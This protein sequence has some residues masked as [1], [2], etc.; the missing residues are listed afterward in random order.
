MKQ[1]KSQQMQLTPAERRWLPWFGGGGKLAMRWS[2]WLNRD[3][4]QVLEH[5]FEGIA[6]IR[7]GLLQ[8]WAETQWRHLESLAEQ[9]GDPL[10]G[11]DAELL[12]SRMAQARDF[13]E[14]LVVSPA[15]EVVCSTAPGR[16]GA[17]D[18][19]PGALA[20]GLKAPFLARSPCGSRDRTTGTVQLKI[21]RCGDADVLSASGGGR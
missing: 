21:P 7:V 2:C 11:L 3:L 17:R 8:R 16:L 18:L 12:K 20:Q 6:R 13:S 1:T 5:T 19:N 14:L 15:G 9:I 4:A 10:S